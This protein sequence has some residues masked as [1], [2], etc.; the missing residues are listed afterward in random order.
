M[1][2]FVS[3]EPRTLF[4]EAGMLL[5]GENFIA[6]LTDEMGFGMRTI[7]RWAGGSRTVP[8]FAWKRLAELLREKE[9]QLG[10]LATNLELRCLLEIR[11]DA[12]S[13]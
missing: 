11:E 13:I 3:Q 1:T 6:R 4:A 12:Q 9:T 10:L 8:P 2:Q 7:E 5:F